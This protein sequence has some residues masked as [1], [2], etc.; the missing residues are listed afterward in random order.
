MAREEKILEQL[1]Q[2]SRM[3]FGVDSDVDEGK[4]NQI[5]SLLANLDDNLRE[6]G[7]GQTAAAME[8]IIRYLHEDGEVSR[9]D[10]ALIRLWMVSDAEFY[11][12]MENDFHNWIIELNRIF[13]HISSLRE[14]Q[15]TPETMGKI[16]GS[17]RDGLRVIADV[18][19]FRQQEQRIERF[20]RATRRLYSEDKLHLARILSQKL[21][22]DA[23]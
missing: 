13:S 16:S 8:A 7:Q 12:Q 21:L 1:D 14:N 19:Y 6:A 11:I 4:L 10:L 22:S 9:E 3:A 17:I 18:I 15:L 23:Q 2:L 5:S 20:E